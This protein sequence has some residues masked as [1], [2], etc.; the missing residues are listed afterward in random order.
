MQLDVLFIKLRTVL[1]NYS[2]GIYT[3][4]A[5]PYKKKR[6]RTYNLGW[7]PWITSTGRWD[8]EPYASIL[9]IVEVLAFVLGC[10]LTGTE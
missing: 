3:D 9:I 10:G 4:T 5:K 6:K 1:K 8:G 7:F 2:L